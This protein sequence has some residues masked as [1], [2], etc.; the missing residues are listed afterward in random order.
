MNNIDCIEKG[1]TGCGA[2]ENICPVNAISIS[3]N[4]TG[5]YAPE[6]DNEKCINCGKCLKVCP[7]KEFEWINSN[8]PKCYAVSASDNDR[9]KSASGGAFP[10]VARYIIENGGY[11]CGVAWD[12]NWEAKHIIIDNIEDIDKLRSSKYVQSTTVDSFKNVKQLL[13]DNKLVLFSGLPCQ[14]AGLYKFLGK[15]YS[16]LYTIDLLCHGSPSPKVWQDWLDKNYDKSKIKNI[17]FRE[18]LD[19]WVRCSKVWLTAKACSS[20]DFNDGTQ[21]PI[22]KYYKAFIKHKISN[23]PCLDCKYRK[24]PRPADITVGDFWHFY[25]SEK[26]DDGLGI[27]VFMC[28][29]DKA[30]DLLKNIK[31]EFKLCHEVQNIANNP[32]WVELRNKSRNSRERE[33]FFKHYN[34]GYDINKCLDEA[35]GEHYDIG[36][37]SF[38]NLRNYGSAL[39]AYAANRMLEDLGYTVLMINK[40]YNS[41][42]MESKSNM[43]LNF[44]KERYNLSRVFNKKDSHAE[45]NLLCDT[46]VV[47]SDTL[48]WDSEGSGNFSWLDFVN[49]DKRKISFATSFAHDN[50]AMNPEKYSMRRYLYSRFDALSTREESG[51]KN[52]KEIFNRDSVQIYDP[53]LIARKEIF[54]EVAQK[55][56]LTNKDFVCAYILDLTKE[57]EDLIKYVVKTLG[58]ELVM[59]SKQRYTGESDIVDRKCIPIEDFIYNFKNAKFVV[60]DSF[61]GTAFSVIYKKDFISLANKKRGL[62]RLKIYNDMGLGN[63]IMPDIVSAYNVDFKNHHA[64]FSKV[65]D[66]LNKERE[67]AITWLKN[68]LTMPKKPLTEADMLFD[69]IIKKESDANKLEIEKKN[70]IVKKTDIKKLSFLEKIFSI[71]N[72]KDKKGVVRKV[73]TILGIKIKIKKK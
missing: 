50:L 45:L 63:C 53:T 33:Q 29:N 17:N 25:K 28:N 71:T 46:F 7:A 67:R 64:D 27:S 56:S 43:S 16:N 58:L 24:I 59:I 49:S 69:Y 66:I 52:L 55:S 32:Q 11:V 37:V 5:F 8:T 41:G 10:V 54:D 18:K 4:K 31:K 34:S 62:A 12:K 68:A 39:V 40:G 72:E 44:A 13:D 21:V 38:F 36:L 35:I 6:I 61:H 73:F 65:D 47:G 57:K 48:W 70:K 30:S 60:T 14:V 19:G 51:V 1:C 2:C 15:E 22:N 20:I 9:K 23:E 3:Y 26:L 42:D